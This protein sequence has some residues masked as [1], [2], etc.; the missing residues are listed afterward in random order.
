MTRQR[1]P[2]PKGQPEEVAG[3]SAVDRSIVICITRL[4]DLDGTPG[5]AV[6]AH[7]PPLTP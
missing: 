3:I 7:F 2:S 4:N 6:T 1:K 5:P